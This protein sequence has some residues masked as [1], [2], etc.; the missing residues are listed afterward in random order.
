[1]VWPAFSQQS[2]LLETGVTALNYNH[3]LVVAENI[4]SRTGET[5]MTIP[6]TK[7]GDANGSTPKPFKLNITCRKQKSGHFLRGRD[8]KYGVS[9]YLMQ[10]IYTGGRILENIRMVKAPAI[11]YHPSGRTCF[12]IRLLSKPISVLNTVAVPNWRTDSHRL[13]SP[14]HRLTG[15][16]YP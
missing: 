14:I 16:D 15:A 5:A 1:M 7:L 4:A 12:I 13:L 11:T 2:P 6:Q 8:M 10:P 9:L 3:D